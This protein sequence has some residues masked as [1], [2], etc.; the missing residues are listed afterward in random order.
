MVMKNRLLLAGRH[1][2]FFASSLEAIFGNPQRKRS[3]TAIGKDNIPL[4]DLT[5]YCTQRPDEHKMWQMPVSQCLG[6]PLDPK[7]GFGG[8]SDGHP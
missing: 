1:D 8:T 3:T 7:Q 2:T 5:M 6:G 4:F